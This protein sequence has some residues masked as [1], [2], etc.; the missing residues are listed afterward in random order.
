MK[1]S[2]IDELIRAEGFVPAELQVIS[3]VCVEV[4]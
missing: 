1:D 4:C 3:R 2:F